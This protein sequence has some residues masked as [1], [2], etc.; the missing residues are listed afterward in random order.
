MEWQRSP[1][2]API[3]VISHPAK[4]AVTTFKIIQHVMSER[5]RVVEIPRP[6]RSGRE[7]PDKIMVLEE[8]RWMTQLAVTSKEMRDEIYCQLVKQLTKNVN[9]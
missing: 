1:I 6:T 9:P 7:S 8:I 5:D 2:S 4:D 3:L